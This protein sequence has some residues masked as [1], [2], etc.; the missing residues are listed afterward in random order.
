MTFKV[1]LKDLVMYV[2]LARAAVIVE[3]ETPGGDFRSLLKIHPA[4]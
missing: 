4:V 3:Q 1:K 2:S